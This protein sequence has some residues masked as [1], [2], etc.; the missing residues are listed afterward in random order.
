MRPTFALDLNLKPVSVNAPKE[1]PHAF[2][3]GDVLYTCEPYATGTGDVP[4]ATKLFVLRVNDDDGTMWLLAEGD[5]PALFHWDNM[6]VAV[7]YDTEDLLPCL[8][9]AIRCPVVELVPNLDGAGEP[10]PASNVRAITLK[11][12]ATIALLVG[13]LAS[14]QAG[15]NAVDLKHATQFGDDMEL[16]HVD[17]V[18][19]GAPTG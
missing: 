4:V 11:V 13:L 7:P 9:A 19:P 5:V 17:L 3:P 1:T 2:Q 8:R 6:L 14:S 18:R 16:I 10:L 15:I 12:V